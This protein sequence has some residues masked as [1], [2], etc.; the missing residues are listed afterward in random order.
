MAIA[1]SHHRRIAPNRARAAAEAH[2]S[3]SGHRDRWAE[4]VL[5]RGHSGDLEQLQLK[6]DHLA[7]IR[8]RV[9]DGA[10]LRP[11]DVLLDVGCGDGL[12]A[13]GALERLGHDGRVVFSDV[14]DD[15]LE[16]CRKVASELGETSRV[17]FV[18]AAADDLAPIGDASVDVVTTRSVLIYVD[19]KRRA[20]EEFFRVIRP[21]GRVSIFEPINNYFPD[22]DDEF[23]GFDA[24]AVADLVAKLSVHDDWDASSDDDPMMNFTERDLLDHAVASGFR[25]VTVDLVVEV[26]PGSWVVDWERLLDVAP[27]PNAPTTRELLERSLTRDERERFISC[28]RPLV[29]AGAGTIRSAFAYVVAHK[30]GDVRP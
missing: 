15:L 16:R 23:W 4:W 22:V 8:G 11:D 21:G 25:S 12:I 5:H 10:A 24:R 20:F 17:R 2:M 29:D 6:M 14:S 30:D 28:M 7:P 1:G 26:R 19:D 27:N 3:A 13:F 18:R 9:L